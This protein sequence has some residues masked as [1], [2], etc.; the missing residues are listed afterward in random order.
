MSHLDWTV[1]E[2]KMIR[3]NKKIAALEAF[4]EAYDK[5]VNSNN[6]ALHAEMYSARNKLRGDD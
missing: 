2:M 4:V 6:V 5:A 3:L 1:N